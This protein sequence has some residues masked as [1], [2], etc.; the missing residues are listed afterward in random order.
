MTLYR[1]IKEAAAAKA[2]IM[3]TMAHF[4][5]GGGGSKYAYIDENGKGHLPIGDACL[6]G[7]TLIALL[8][9]TN[10]PIADLVGQQVWIYAFDHQKCAIVPALAHD[11]RQTVVASP[12]VCVVLDNG[13][14][15]VCTADHRFLMRDGNYREARYLSGGDSIMP[16]YRK[17]ENAFRR[18]PQEPKPYE[19]IWQPYYR[20]WE[21]THM[22]V[23]RETHGPL[24]DGNIVHHKNENQL[25]NQPD[26]VQQMSRAAHLSHHADT[27]DSEHV[28]SRRANL[29]AGSKARWARLGERDKHSAFMT[30]ENL[31]RKAAGTLGKRRR[32]APFANHESV[33]VIYAR[34]LAGAS[35]NQLAKDF[36]VSKAGIKKAFKREGLASRREALAINNHRIVSVEVGPCVDVFDMSVDEHHNFALANGIFVHNSHVRNAIARYN[37]T[38]FESDAKAKAAWAHIMGAARKF[39]IDVEDKSKPAHKVKKP[40][41]GYERA[42]AASE[43]VCG[44][45]ECEDMDSTETLISTCA[46]VINGDEAPEWIELIPPGEFSAVDGRGPFK[47]DKPDDI[48][49]ASMAKMPAAGLV[50][51]FDHSTDLAAPEGRPSPAAG[52]LKEFKEEGGAI[53]ARIEWTAAAAEAVKAK[54]YRYISPVF[55]HSKDGEVERILRAALTNN[56]ALI[57]LPAIAAAEIASMETATMARKKKVSDAEQL[58][59]HI[60]ALG[61]MFPE[62]SHDQLLSMARAHAAIMGGKSF[63]DW[64][65]EEEQEHAAA[66][67][68]DDDE[69][70]DDD[71][72]IPPG[73]NPHPIQEPKPEPT[74]G[75]ADESAEQMAK[76]HEE[77]MA[78]CA[79]DGERAQCASRHA[80]EKEEFA[81]RQAPPVQNA[82][83]S[84][85]NVQ[86]KPKP[87]KPEQK[88]M[89]EKELEARIAA[90]PMVVSMASEINAMRE[91]KA[92]AEAENAVDAAIRDGRIIPSQREWAISYCT[93]TPDG[94]KTFLDSQ[95]RILQSGA[96]GTF[97]GRIGEAKQ[98]ENALNKAELMVC[99]N[100]GGIDPEKFAAAKKFRLSHNVHLD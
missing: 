57:E 32:L 23:D 97:T 82:H 95:P 70:S 83:M 48:I 30:Q 80:K 46:M 7:D 85:E 62:A 53:F 24:L 42:A 45:G 90:H 36:D 38:H 4:A 5:E 60:S 72:G 68:G 75:A 99:E 39:G 26:N 20:F 98:D 88:E 1:R 12:T 55:E 54:H 13:A 59:S 22:M 93:S 81:K 65:E 37:Q 15:V 66:D 78:R 16:L 92:K 14:S 56:P 69:G 34:Y 50:L 61:G 74:Q 47:N 67:D 17:F 3:G 84:A 25:D 41:S 51:D 94:F 100:L 86:P 31:R 35:L 63:K 19:Q 91:A 71:D 49:A 43:E 28:A 89:T 27:A 79:D 29:V 9:G 77:E 58:A 11:I 52:W 87:K 10:R 96:D 64:A 6:A 40:S 8:D 73:A 76:R 33:M 2:R 21:Q 44:C 18:K